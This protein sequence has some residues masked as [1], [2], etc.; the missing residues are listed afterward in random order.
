M[1]ALVASIREDLSWC[2]AVVNAVSGGFEIIGG[3]AEA[4]WARTHVFASNRLSLTQ[5]GGEFEVREFW[6]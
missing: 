5:W 1:V 4:E 2:T 6:R 3:Y